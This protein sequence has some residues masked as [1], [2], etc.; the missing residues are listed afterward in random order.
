MNT[1]AAGHSSRPVTKAARWSFAL[2]A[3]AMACASGAWAA[4][5]APGSQADATYRKDRAACLSGQSQQDRAA[6][7][8]EAG[9]ARDAA[10]HGQLRT[11]DPKTL[12][13]NAVERCRVQPAGDGREACL[14]MARGGGMVSGSPESGGQLRELVTTVP[15]TAASAAASGPGTGASAAR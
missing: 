1:P 3:A 10:L 4:A 13:A 11:A 15:A 14:R 6:C 8:K 12:D 2:A 9:A 7:L 5:S